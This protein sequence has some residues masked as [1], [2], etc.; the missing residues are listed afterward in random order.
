MR[1]TGVE[2]HRGGSSSRAGAT[3]GGERVSILGMLAGGGF[4]EKAAFA[5]GLDFREPWEKALVR[6]GKR[7]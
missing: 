1:A 2:V 4:V 7:G 5:A 6:V 3:V